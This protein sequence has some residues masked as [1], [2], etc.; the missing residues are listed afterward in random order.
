M[1]QRH[2]TPTSNIQLNQDTEETTPNM[3]LK[4]HMCTTETRGYNKP[5]F[6]LVIYKVTPVKFFPFTE[7]SNNA[8]ILLLPKSLH[9]IFYNL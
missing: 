5:F 1:P 3:L 6:F 4:M 7:K 8:T 2:K 9:Y